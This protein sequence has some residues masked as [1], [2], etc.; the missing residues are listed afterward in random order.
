[1]LDNAASFLHRL[2]DQMG[3]EL[4]TDTELQ[5]CWSYTE[6]L[7]QLVYNANH[8]FT[9]VEHTLDTLYDILA[10]GDCSCSHLS[11]QFKSEQLASVGGCAHVCTRDPSIAQN[12]MM[13]RLTTELRH[14][15][16]HVPLQPLDAHLATSELHA[17][18]SVVIYPPCVQIK[19]TTGESGDTVYLDIH[20]RHGSSGYTMQTFRKESKLPF[21]PIEYT[22]FA[23][24]RPTVAGY[25][26]IIGLVRSAVYHA[27]GAAKAA[28]DVFNIVKSYQHNGYD[29]QKLLAI[30]RRTVTEGQFP[31]V[32]FD[33][34]GVARFLR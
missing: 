18:A 6:S 2:L 21:E 15:L 3:H 12:I 30:A 5:V 8:T 13:I 1:L 14:G 17:M 33:T 7:G 9:A 28:K 31:G 20:T 25:N 22:A 32:R 26:G 27:S 34:E 4:S 16:K 11:S 23:S 29:R 24:N 19:D 10:A